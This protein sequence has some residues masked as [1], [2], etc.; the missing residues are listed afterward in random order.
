M[1][2]VIEVPVSR[3]N[4]IRRYLELKT[5]SENTPME[6]AVWSEIVKR[7]RIKT[8]ERKEIQKILGLN[9]FSLNNLIGKLKEKSCIQYNPEDRSLSSNIQF[10]ENIEQ[11]TFKFNLYDTV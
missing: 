8:R 11:L 1:E 9:Q 5:F 10:P 2:E 4:L 3:D 6:Y 7:G